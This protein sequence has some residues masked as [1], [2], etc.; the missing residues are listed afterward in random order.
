MKLPAT[1]L[2]KQTTMS[3]TMRNLFLI[4]SFLVMISCSSDDDV[5]TNQP[6]ETMSGYVI[7]IQDTPIEGSNFPLVKYIIT[8]TIN[9]G[10]FVSEQREFFINGVSQG[11]PSIQTEY[12]YQNGLVTKI[13]TNTRVYDLFYD[14]QGRMIAVNL[15]TEGRYYRF[16][17]LPN[18]IVYFERITLPYNNP[19]LEVSRR[20]ILKFDADDNIIEYGNDFNLSGIVSNNKIITYA[21]GDLVQIQNSNGTIENFLFS[22]V[23]NNFNILIFNSFGKRNRNIFNS[24][25]LISNQVYILSKHISQ[26]D[27]ATDTY[28]VLPNGFYS[29]KTETYSTDSHNTERTTEFFF[30]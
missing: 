1:T 20:Y 17:H 21:N 3:K 30:E 29:K 14:A 24:E 27:F 16:Q 5:F 22:S 18:N 25:C 4:V 28:E 8:G 23:I 26:E 6:F 19:N 7:N 10:K 13:I 12:I 15:E 2:R 9:N 11:S